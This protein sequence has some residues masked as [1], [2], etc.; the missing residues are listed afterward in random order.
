MAF[1]NKTDWIRLSRIGL[2][3]FGALAAGAIGNAARA[4]DPMPNACPVDGC[5]VKIV[6]V[7]KADGGELE[8]T[9]E[10]NY[11]PDM[12]KNHVHV[13]WGE[14][15]KIEQVTGNA[16]TVYKVKQGEWHPTGDYPT[17]VTKSAASTSV[18][19]NAHT[20]CVSPADRDHNVLDVKVF[21]CVD[22]SG[23][24]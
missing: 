9:F 23:N 20:L 14:N 21:Q 24:L 18:R 19:G 4:D 12:S 6:G 1:T 10:A 8:V 11:T 13:W 2:A 7:K 5:A 3:M 15:Y 16:E 17:Y 22:V